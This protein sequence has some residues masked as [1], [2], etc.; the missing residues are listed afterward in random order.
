GRPP[1]SAIRGPPGHGAALLP[2]RPHRG[3]AG[4]AAPPRPLRP[5]PRRTPRRSPPRPAALLVVP[6]RHARAIIMERG[7]RH[8]WSGYAGA[9][10]DSRHR[11]R[12][13][14][15]LEDPGAGEV[16]RSGDPR[17]QARSGGA[18]PQAG[19]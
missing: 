18:R 12:P 17:V 8:V 16:P 1:W 7:D 14:R 6:P 15:R 5:I 2:P 13:V 4:G 19:G 10:V 3:R 11:P 9:D